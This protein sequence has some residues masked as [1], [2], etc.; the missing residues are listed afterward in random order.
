MGHLVLVSW[1]AGVSHFVQDFIVSRLAQPGDNDFAHRQQHGGDSS[2]WRAN[3]LGGNTVL[4]RYFCLQRACVVFGVMRADGSRHIRVPGTLSFSSQYPH[5]EEHLRDEAGFD[6]GSMYESFVHQNTSSRLPLR[7]D[8]CRLS[9]GEILTMRKLRAVYWKHKLALLV[10]L[11][12][13]YSG[14]AVFAAAPFLP[15]KCLT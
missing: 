12:L 14:I 3:P 10:L 5:M 15:L 2:L 8:F 9:P 13:T 11:R 1:R 6:P 7:K 4:K